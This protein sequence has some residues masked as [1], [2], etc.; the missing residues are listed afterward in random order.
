MQPS[1]SW[2]PNRVYPFCLS[3][4]RSSTLLNEWIHTW[5]NPNFRFACREGSKK[6]AGSNRFSTSDGNDRIR[7]EFAYTKCYLPFRI[8]DRSNQNVLFGESFMQLQTVL[9]TALAIIVL[10]VMGI[11][12][13]LPTQT[14]VVTPTFPTPAAAE[15]TPVPTSVSTQVSTPL[16]AALSPVNAETQ[17]AAPSDIE[18]MGKAVTAPHETTQDVSTGQP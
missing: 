17:P 6:P 4:P 1:L 15:P 16:P 9:I 14:P 2:F 3:L 8:A 7:K 5:V 10:L 11:I 18:P 12:I 13:F